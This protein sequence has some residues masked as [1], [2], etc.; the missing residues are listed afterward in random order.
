MHELVVSPAQEAELEPI[1]RQSRSSR[2][3]AFRARIIL[4]C[5]GEPA[6]QR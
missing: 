5:A 2:S 4:E 3:V 6:I 1:S